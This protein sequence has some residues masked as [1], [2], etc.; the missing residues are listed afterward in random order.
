[1]LT[2]EI[3]PLRRY[4]IQGLKKFNNLGNTKSKA[5]FIIKHA[6]K[7]LVLERYAIMI[8][9]REDFVH[10]IRTSTTLLALSCHKYFFSF[11]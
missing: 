4:V 11:L 10:F 2:N 6:S 5:L 1:M 8:M 3:L 9:R 7:L